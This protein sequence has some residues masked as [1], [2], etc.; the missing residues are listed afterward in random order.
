M[1]FLLDT[2]VPSELTKPQIDP[3]VSAWVNGNDALYMSVISIGEMRKGIRLLPKGRKRQELEGVLEYS[4]MPLFADRILPVTQAIAER[5]GDITALRRLMGVPL[6]PA[7]GLIAATAL[8]YGLTAVTR[9]G[10]DFVGLGLTILNPWE[11]S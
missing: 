2:N 9:N 5:W 6:H 7:D 11:A 1:S 8:E 3:R 4:I 10:D